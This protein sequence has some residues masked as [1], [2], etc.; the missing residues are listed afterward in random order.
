MSQ[1]RD[2]W[3]ILLAV[4]VVVYAQNLGYGEVS[5]TDEYEKQ[6]KRLGRNQPSSFNIARQDPT[7]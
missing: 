1:A 3:L 2:L 5:T 7:Q 4:T 6:N